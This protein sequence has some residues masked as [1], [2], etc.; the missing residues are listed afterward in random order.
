MSAAAHFLG[1]DL[2]DDA[3]HHLA[4][5]LTGAFADQ[6]IPGIRTSPTNWHLTVRYLGAVP[7]ERLEATIHHLSESDLG[8]SFSLQLDGLGAFPRPEKATVLWVG[9]GGGTEELLLLAERVE[10]ALEEMG[11]PREDR[12]FAPHLTLSRIRPP[13]DVW[14]WLEADPIL[15]VRVPV[16]TLTLFR[17]ERRPTAYPAVER[18]PL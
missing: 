8:A 4:A 2:D 9:T 7:P 5:A 17:S 16:G 12:P 13:T 14:T 6:P 3:R 11:W 18:F 1:I 15:D 10:E